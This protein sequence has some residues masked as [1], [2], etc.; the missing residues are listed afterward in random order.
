VNWISVHGKRAQR[1][2]ELAQNTF[3]TVLLF[4][5]GENFLGVK[6]TFAGIGA[7]GQL[8]GIKSVLR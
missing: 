6:K 7:R 4:G 5:A 3:D 2:P 1:E 8:D